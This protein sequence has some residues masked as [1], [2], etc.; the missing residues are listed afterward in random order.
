[1][2]YTVGED[3]ILAIWDINKKQLKKKTLIDFPAYTLNISRDGL[4]G[5]IGCSNGSLFLFNPETLAIDKTKNIRQSK[6]ITFV[7]YSPDSNLLCVG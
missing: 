5:A 7:K 3:K 4:N 6:G 1:L 2:A